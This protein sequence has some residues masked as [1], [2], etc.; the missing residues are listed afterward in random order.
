MIP[1]RRHPWHEIDSS[2]RDLNHLFNNVNSTT[3]SSNGKVYLPPAEL[4][5]TEDAIY[6]KFEIPGM[7]AKDID[8]QA[9]TKAVSI[10]GERKSL[11]RTDAEAKKRSEFR[12]GGFRRDISL[13]VRV[14]NTSIKAKYQNGILHLTLPK[15]ESEKIKVV[16]I[17]AS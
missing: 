12:Y 15:D 4:T 6:L 17:N 14:Q 11:S 5:E 1:I 8:I 16:K 2:Q 3:Q 9:S 10:S 7:E 13:P